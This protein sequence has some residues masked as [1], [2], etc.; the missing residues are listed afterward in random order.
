MF[1]PA[2]LGSYIVIIFLGSNFSSIYFIR[3]II[4]TC[5]EVLV[6]MRFFIKLL[7]SLIRVDIASFFDC[8]YMGVLIK[9]FVGY[10][11]MVLSFLIFVEV[12]FN[13][14]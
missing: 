9:Y 4:I 7:V 13:Q 14:V 10:W 5:Y 11:T 12:E 3:T 2:L 6:I 8:Y 1:L